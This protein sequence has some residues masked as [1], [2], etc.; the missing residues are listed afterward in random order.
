MGRDGVVVTAARG[1]RA[2]VAVV[3]VLSAVA[4][5][6]AQNNHS[7]SWPDRCFFDHVSESLRTC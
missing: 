1:Y 2:V 6:G 4:V 5:R 7:Q 3:A